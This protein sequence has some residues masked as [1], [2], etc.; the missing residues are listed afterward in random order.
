LLGPDGK[1]KFLDD[2][3]KT[4]IDASAKQLLREL[5]HAV[6]SLADAEQLRQE[7]ERTVSVKK[8]AKQG[9]GAIGR[10]AAGG[11]LTAKSPEELLEEAR[12]NTIKMHRESIIW[13]LQRQL[14]ECGRYQSSMMEIRLMR[15]V[16][17]NKSILYKARGTLPTNDIEM[18]G[19]TG[20]Y[21]GKS[22]AQQETESKA[23]EEQLDPEQL[24]LFAQ[25]NQDMLRHYEDTLDQVRYALPES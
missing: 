19:G 16:E 11:A 24:Q 4:E 21:R 9:F 25:E 18:E 1:T 13:Y 8:R 17:K 20:A 15:E 12:A 2:K 10:W 14:E 7:A 23:L 3:E 5:N 22:T 6:K